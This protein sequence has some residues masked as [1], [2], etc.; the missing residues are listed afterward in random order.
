MIRLILLTKGRNAAC[1]ADKDDEHAVSIWGGLSHRLQGFSNQGKHELKKKT[2]ST[3]TLR[4]KLSYCQL[5]KF[6]PVIS[7]IL[8]CYNP[9]EAA[10]V[11]LGPFSPKT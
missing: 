1:K 3:W 8:Q 7:G 4:S 6:L 9:F 2:L 5:M 11:M 10:T